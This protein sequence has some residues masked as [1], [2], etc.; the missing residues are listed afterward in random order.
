MGVVNF[1]GSLSFRGTI[2]LVLSCMPS[3]DLPLRIFLLKYRYRTRYNCGK[4]DQSFVFAVNARKHRWLCHR[5]SMKHI[6]RLNASANLQEK[7]GSNK[8]ATSDNKQTG[9]FSPLL[10]LE[11]HLDKRARKKVN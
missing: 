1:P 4:C 6:L 2:Y 10:E 9:D 7:N 11:T 8:D 5:K 3:V